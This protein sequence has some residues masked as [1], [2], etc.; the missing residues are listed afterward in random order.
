MENINCYHAVNLRK[1]KKIS[2]Q[3]HTHPNTYYT[4][5][6]QGLSDCTLC[7]RKCHVD[8]TAGQTGF[9]GQSDRIM[10]AR[11]ALHFWEEPCLS[12]VNGSGAVF[13]SGC[14]LRCIY[15]QNHTIV[16]GQNGKEISVERLSEIFLELQE[17]QAHNINL[18]TPTHYVPQIINA[19]QT[20][21]DNG[22]AIPVVYNTSGYENVDTLKRLEGLIDIYLPDLKYHDSALS[23]RYSNAPDYFVKATA[24]IS[25]MLRQTG[26]PVFVDG[27]DSLMLKGVIVRHLL[28]PGCEAD[29]RYLIRYLHETYRN[30]IYVSIMNQYTPMPN[31]AD[32]PSLNCRISS[33]EYDRIVDYAIHIG[34]E[35]GFIQE[36]ETAS[37]SFIPPFDCEGI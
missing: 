4:P 10:A 20:A 36:G 14:N 7:P 11:A 16:Q 15:C 27:E 2:L 26:R 8:R 24:A 30:D 29:S 3:P 18:V 23:A 5:F 6:Q 35:N 1:M 22:L 13:F 21:K 9:C 31:V 17:K 19:L 25:E 32:H 28:L 34:I 12:G 33:E 37:E